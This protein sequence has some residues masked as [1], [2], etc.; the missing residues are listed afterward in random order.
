MA[1]PAAM[2]GQQSSAAVIILAIDIL[3]FSLT[4]NA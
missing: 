3:I 2:P 1:H 4:G